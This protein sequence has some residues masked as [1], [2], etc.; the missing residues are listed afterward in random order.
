MKCVVV[1][2]GAGFVGSHTCLLLLEMGY[3]IFII[4]SLENSF[5]DTFDRIKK[6]NDLSNYKNIRIVFI[7]KSDLKDF[8]K[9]EFIFEEIKRKEFKIECVFH[10]AGLNLCSKID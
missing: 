3:T 7:Y 6:L 5:I 4:D 9:L 2:G 1:T 8:A 10:F